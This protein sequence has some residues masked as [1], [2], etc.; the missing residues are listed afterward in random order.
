MSQTE[1]ERI[2]LEYRGKVM[3]YLKARIKNRAEAEDLCSDVFEK[4][5]RKLDQFDRTKASLSTWIYSIARNTLI[6]HFRRMHP[7]DELDEN[8]PDGTEVDE[9]L[10]RTERLGE[11]ADALRSL[12]QQ[13]MDII[14]LRYYDG[15]QL[16]QIADMMQI[17]YG[18]VKLRHQKALTLLKAQMA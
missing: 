10:L 15:K 18:A 6:D 2:Y 7:G 1:M 4:I 5:Y 3:G 11:L 14:I 16:T 13:L 12:P 9:D 17:S 8:M